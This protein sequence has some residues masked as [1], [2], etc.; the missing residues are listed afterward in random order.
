MDAGNFLTVGMGGVHVPV[1]SVMKNK[2]VKLRD[3]ALEFRSNILWRPPPWILNTRLY[4]WVLVRTLNSVRDVSKLYRLSCSYA[5][6]ALAQ[7][8]MLPSRSS[9]SGILQIIQKSLHISLISSS[10]VVAVAGCYILCLGL[11]NCINA[12]VLYLP[13]ILPIHVSMLLSLSFL[14]M[15]HMSMLLSMCLSLSQSLSFPAYG[16]YA[17]HGSMI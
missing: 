4:G 12:S 8:D 1:F 14:P 2:R 13:F 9:Y 17:Q 16:M 11:M 7:M 3:I 15:K 6:H 10:S 5:S